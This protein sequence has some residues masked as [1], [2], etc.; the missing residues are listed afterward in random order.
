VGEWAITD[1][2]GRGMQECFRKYP[3]IYGAELSEDDADDGEPDVDANTG[4]PGG[5]PD[6]PGS[7]DV[8]LTESVKGDEST[9][10]PKTS[11]SI[12]TKAPEAINESKLEEAKVEDPAPKKPSEE[13]KP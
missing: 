13:E 12:D 9:T 2:A 1:C 10:T 6:L 11:D 3:E 4:A 7:P 5:L 8:P